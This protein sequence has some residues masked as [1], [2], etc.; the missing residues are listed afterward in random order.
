MRK[1]KSR[2]HYRRTIDAL[3]NYKYSQPT[4]RK[5]T[6]R[7]GFEPTETFTSLDFKSN[8]ESLQILQNSGFQGLNILKMRL[9]LNQKMT[10][11][12]LIHSLL[13]NVMLF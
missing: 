10:L 9:N 11:E 4:V 2:R 5:K 6:E 13:K 7:V 12:I 8:S 3:H 1:T